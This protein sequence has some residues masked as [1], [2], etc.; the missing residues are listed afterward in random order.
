MRPA[1][2]RPAAMSATLT[3][4]P[5]ATRTAT[6]TATLSAAMAAALALL[7]SPARAH[8]MG[9]APSGQEKCYGVALAGQNHCAN[10]RSS[11][12]C[13]GQATVDKD[14]GEFRLV[15]AGTCKQLKGLSEAQARARLKP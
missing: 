3:V 7:A 11:H 10:L 8:S 5:T 1:F 14:K 4:T 15:P 12:D 6:R 13:A 2:D 9:D